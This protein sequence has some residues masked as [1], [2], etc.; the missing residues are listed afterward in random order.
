MLIYK[1]EF[2]ID[3]GRN[4]EWFEPVAT[5]IKYYKDNTEQNR[6]LFSN[7]VGVSDKNFV[8]LGISGEYIGYNITEINVE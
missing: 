8:N 4:R 2:T 5:H 7:I 6:L 1:Y 3:S